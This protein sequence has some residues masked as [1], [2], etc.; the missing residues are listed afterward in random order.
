M[1]L[2]P[3]LETFLGV[4]KSIKV[5]QIQ[6][7]IRHLERRLALE[8]GFPSS[9]VMRRKFDKFVQRELA[10][11]AGFRTIKEWKHMQEKSK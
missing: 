5:K 1:P 6:A 2:K 11:K 3:I 8:M 4:L 9:T 7:E 10:T